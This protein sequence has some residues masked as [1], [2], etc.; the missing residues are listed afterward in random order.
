MKINNWILP[1]KKGLKNTYLKNFEMATN[2]LF[3][4]FFPFNKK[5]TGVTVNKLK[6][7][8]SL[9]PKNS[10]E[11]KTTIFLKQTKHSLEDWLIISATKPQKKKKCNS[12]TFHENA[13]SDLKFSKLNLQIKVFI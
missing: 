2:F 10:R 7:R 5:I 6:P 8:P 11:I 4:P 13:L 12:A 9:L 3:S 1:T